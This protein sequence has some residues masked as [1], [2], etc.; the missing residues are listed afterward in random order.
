MSTELRCH[1]ANLHAI[2]TDDGL[3]E[4]KCASR[5]C[6]YKPGVVVL[7]YFDPLNGELVKTNKFSDPKYNLRRKKEI[8]NESPHSNPAALRA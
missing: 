4:V 8:S 6:G 3:L 7:H 1:P 5:F 2:L